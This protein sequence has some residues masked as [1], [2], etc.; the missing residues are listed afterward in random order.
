MRQF[1]AVAL[2]NLVEVGYQFAEAIAYLLAVNVQGRHHDV[3]GRQVH[4]LQDALAQVGFH[5]V[6]ARSLQVLV[7]VT[8]LGE[9]ALAL[10]HL[11]HLVAIQ[12][13]L[14]NAVVFIG[15]LGPV[16]ADAVFHGVGLKLLQIVGQMGGR[17]LLDLA[18]GL[19]Q[20]FPFGQSLGH[21]VALLAHTEES[22][23]VA[24]HHVVVL[25]IALCSF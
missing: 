13:V 23:V 1:R 25:Q 17:V 10:H 2:G 3:A 8:L 4:E 19:A 24:T 21:V 14:H 12:N 9:H 18:G 7:Q 15:I 22:L 20:V 16:H 5:H 6:E 11:F